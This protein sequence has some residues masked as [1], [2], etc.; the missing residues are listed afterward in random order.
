MGLRDFFNRR[1]R[2]HMDVLPLPSSPPPL[3]LRLL[4]TAYIGAEGSHRRLGVLKSN[5]SAAIRVQSAEEEQNQVYSMPK[6]AW[7][8]AEHKMWCGHECFVMMIFIKKFSSNVSFFPWKRTYVGFR[9]W[10]TKGVFFGQC[11]HLMCR[12]NPTKHVIMC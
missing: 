2:P 8:R 5:S 6:R 11:M 3:V 1:P 10:S 12:S 7:T 4:N 9:F